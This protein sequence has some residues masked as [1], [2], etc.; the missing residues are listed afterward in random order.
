[1]TKIKKRHFGTALLMFLLFSC[2]GENSTLTTPKTG[3]E[4]TPLNMNTSFSAIFSQTIKK[5]RSGSFQSDPVLLSGSS[6]S[7]PPKSQSKSY[8]GKMQVINLFTE[9]KEEFDWPLTQTMDDEG[10]II[11]VSHPE[12]SLKS[13][14]Y[15]FLLL[16]TSKDGLKSQYTAKALT[17]RILDGKNPLIRFVLS[18]NLGK[19]IRHFD[20]INSLSTLRF[21]WTEAD[22]VGLHQPQFGISINEGDE[23]VYAINKQMGLSP[24][25]LNV[26]PGE[27]RLRMRLYDGDKM[28]GKNEQDENLITLIEGENAQVKMIPLQVGINIRLDPIKDESRFSFIVPSEIV[29]EVGGAQNLT[30]LVR[31]GGIGVP[32][33]EK[34]LDVLDNN[35]IFKASGIF[36][37]GGQAGVTVY[38]AFHRTTE[39]ATQFSDV[40]LARCNTRINVEQTKTLGCNLELKRESLL[41]RSIL[42]T[43]MLNVLDEENQSAMGAEVFLN[44]ELMGLTGTNYSTGSIKTQR[45][46]GNYKLKVQKEA[47]SASADFLLAPLEMKNEFL[48]LETQA[49]TMDFIRLPDVELP[50]GFT[51][52]NGELLDFDGDGDLD[53]LIPRFEKNELIVALN[54]GKGK[55]TVVEPA[56]SSHY[57]L[58]GLVVADIDGDKDKDILVLSGI[59][60]EEAH[61]FFYNQ[62]N[63]YFTPGQKITIEAGYP[64]HF[65]TENAE[66]IAK[67]GD[68]DNDGDLDLITN[69]KHDSLGIFINDGKGKYTKHPFEPFIYKSNPIGLAIA[70]FNQDKYQDIY[71]GG[72][73]WINNQQGDFLPL[74]IPSLKSAVGKVVSADFNGDG[75]P[76]LFS[77]GGTHPESGKGNQPARLFLNKG[78]GE[79]T[80]SAQ[81]FDTQYNIHDSSAA[82]FNGDAIAD[83]ITAMDNKVNSYLYSK[84]PEMIKTKITDDGLRWIKTGDLDNDG[85]IDL[86]NFLTHIRVYLNQRIP[87]AIHLAS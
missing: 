66:G 25:T 1:M 17:Q 59:F 4:L 21:S 52:H 40:P 54:D 57:S 67:F 42:G 23:S 12:L 3:N 50:D 73:I 87:N 16:L 41:T 55:F 77:N 47:L 76:D 49:D 70:D 62:G 75:A 81:D 45:V 31:L 56:F 28:L 64:A 60:S 10:N 2:G 85:D 32:V 84:N 39:A 9:S 22:L 51:H 58:S 7:V 13:G 29:T 33:Q 80:V 37:T 36:E 86:M 6:Q 15:D 53:A 18:P 26:L 83:L 63:G 11:G 72:R 34:R 79:F 82:D 24:V 69:I 78:N 71:A 65:S 43:L 68:L 44:G 19:T 30:L 61:Q 35:G 74:N 48:N 14:T 27:Y 5:D 20:E 8:N 38:L 46:A